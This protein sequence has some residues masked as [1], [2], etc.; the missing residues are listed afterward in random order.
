MD[1]TGSLARQVPLRRRSCRLQIEVAR[2]R[3]GSTAKILLSLAEWKC[4]AILVSHLALPSVRFSTR[5]LS[6]RSFGSRQLTIP[7]Q[8]CNPGQQA[9]EACGSQRSVALAHHPAQPLDG[10]RR[11]MADAVNGEEDVIST[12]N[13]AGQQSRAV[14][15]T[16]VVMQK[17][18]ACALD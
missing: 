14:L 17:M 7:A 1:P 18:P 4:L 16:T 6:A 9:G 8:A 5:G 11:V 12:A 2:E 15:D 13:E 3:S 10:R